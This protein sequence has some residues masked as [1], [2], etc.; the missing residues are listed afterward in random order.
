[1]IASPERFTERQRGEG[2]DA[3]RSAHSASTPHSSS[4]DLI[5][6]VDGWDQD[7]YDFATEP[8]VKALGPIHPDDHRDGVVTAP[9]D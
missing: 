2:H 7:A 5:G 3:A 1:M 6:T 4:R 9:A 8:W